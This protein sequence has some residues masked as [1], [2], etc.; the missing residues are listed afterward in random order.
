MS[1]ADAGHGLAVEFRGFT[2]W[3]WA[4]LLFGLAWVVF[5]FVVL[6]VDI[7]TVGAVAVIAGVGLVVGG[8]TDIAEGFRATS[9]RW[10]HVVMGVASVLVGAI[11][12]VWPEVTFLVLAALVGWVAMIVGVAHVV[13]AL[14]SRRDND[15][16]W[17]LLIAGAFE[18]GVGLWAVGYDGRS[19][20]LLI[21]WVGFAA[22]GR[23]VAAMVFAF[24]LRDVD[25]ELARR[26]T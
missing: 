2:K 10:V 4:P 16:W 13:V 14:T 19:V 1:S 18:I 20:A 25:Q 24:G 5:G 8:I 12:L 23:G 9:W 17:T 11:A 22:I 7:T 26:L 3:W 6:S 21:V 15:L